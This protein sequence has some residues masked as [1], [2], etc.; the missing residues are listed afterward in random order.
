MKTNTL[1]LLCLFALP[2]CDVAKT[3][4]GEPSQKTMEEEQPSKNYLDAAPKVPAMLKK[5]SGCNP[6]RV[7]VVHIIKD[8]AD[9][10][11]QQSQEPLKVD[12]WSLGDYAPKGPEPVMFLDGKPTTESM[13]AATFDLER[14]V[15]WSKL[16]SVIK[17][18]TELSGVA[19]LEH[20]G[21]H[22][23][24][25]WSTG[26][27]SIAVAVKGLRAFETVHF[28]GDGRLLDKMGELVD[29]GSKGGDAS[30]TKKAP[31]PTPACS[32][33]S[34]DPLCPCL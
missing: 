26:R 15:N 10:E 29:E 22:I 27:P 7:I 19:E 17:R 30:A 4:L 28:D 34:S 16:P 20:V 5:K 31:A 18:G 23:R 1:V 12:K 14:D 8:S 32:C 3:F 21:V 33:K 25:H 2:S 11:I 9:A 13:K 24:N 6:C